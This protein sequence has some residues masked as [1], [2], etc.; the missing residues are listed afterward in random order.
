VPRLAAILVVV[1][2]LMLGITVLSFRLGL[3]Q[4]LSIAL[5][6][7][8]ILAMTIERMSIVWEERGFGGDGSRRQWA[9]CSWP[10]AAT[11]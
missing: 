4:G 8:V 11:S 5:F 9:R 3:E 2:C 7:M 1:V 10:S 6:P